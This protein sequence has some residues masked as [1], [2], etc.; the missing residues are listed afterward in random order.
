MDRDENHL[1]EEIARLEEAVADLEER[2]RDLER[3]SQMPARPQRLV[4]QPRPVAPFQMVPPPPAPPPPAPPRRLSL[5]LPHL[6]SELE[7]IIGTSWL[8][9]LGVIAIIASAAYFLKYSF[10]NQWIG[11]A[12]RVALTC[13][14][15]LALLLAGDWYQRRRL[16]VFAQGLSGGGLAALFFAVYAAFAIYRLIGFVPAFALMVLTTVASVVLATRYNSMAIATLGLIGGFL[17]PLLLGGDATASTGPTGPVS[18]GLYLYFLLLA[19]GAYVLT[20]RRRWWRFGG[21]GLAAAFLVPIVVGTSG[22][23]HPSAATVYF[24]LI[25]LGTLLLSLSFNAVRMA[26]TALAGGFLLSQLGG[27]YG[28][29]AMAGLAYFGVITVASTIVAL[30]R[31]WRNVAVAATVAGTLITF[32][33]QPKPVIVGFVYL[34]VIA[35]VALLATVRRNWTWTDLIVV[36]STGYSATALASNLPLTTVQAQSIAGVAL[37]F[38]LFSLT[39]SLNSRDRTEARLLS[40]IVAAALAAWQLFQILG[41]QARDALALAAIVL[42]LYHVVLARA[43]MRRGLPQLTLL[44]L[45]GLAL[46]FLTIA[47]PLKLRQEAIP[48]AW[49]VEGAALAWAA[50]RTGNTWVGRAAGVVGLVA[51]ARL[52]MIET[53]AISS[54]GLILTGPGLAFAA[55]IAGLAIQAR[56]LRRLAWNTPEDRYIAPGLGALA[57]ALLLWW[58]GWEIDGGFERA[59]PGFAQ[60]SGA[61]QATLS[62]W[63]TLYGFALV[64]IGIWRDLAAVRWAGIGLLAVTVFKVF[65]IDL[66]AVAV[67]FRILS[68]MILGALLLAA[69]LAYSRYRARLAGGRAGGP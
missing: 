62:A 15:G 46:T 69:S 11:P 56:F 54:G 61:K 3:F 31:D 16:S 23:P 30:R 5:D 13:L 28:V 22:T 47:I 64:V 43:L 19:G 65:F 63:F 1:R 17:T 66:S 55:G 44:L 37:L 38:V 10:D 33:I 41:P 24:L 53:P 21:V 2:V 45:L 4:A 6:S 67:V 42:A 9:R 29:N 14:L 26:W 51:A 57:A 58:G 52:L 12:G 8:N 7:V 40:V 60:T 48:L 18:P 49:T 25:T 59:S 32:I 34:A 36:L 39:L 27:A 50:A 35:A 68:L 20:M